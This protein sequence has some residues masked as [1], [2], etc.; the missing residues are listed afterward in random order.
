MGAVAG[1]HHLAVAHGQDRRAGLDFRVDRQPNVAR[2]WVAGGRPGWT[3]LARAAPAAQGGRR[4]RGG[5][6]FSYRVR[7]GGGRKMIH[8]RRGAIGGKKGGDGG[9][10]APQGPAT[11]RNEMARPCAGRKPL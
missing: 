8:W 4:A 9:S 1:P 5:N 6:F 3:G 10:I 2:L 11:S 7:G